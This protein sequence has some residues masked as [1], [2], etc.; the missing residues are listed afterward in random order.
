[1]VHGT[2]LTTLLKSVEGDGDME[3]VTSE[4]GNDVMMWKWTISLWLR[5]ILLTIKRLRRL[6]VLPRPPNTNNVFFLSSGAIP[7]QK[8]WIASG[9]SRKVTSDEVSNPLTNLSSEITA[10]VTT[11]LVLMD[12]R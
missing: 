6:I 4:N 5:H 2:D 9:L 1:M 11:S 8:L 10:P 3:A 7:L 12:F